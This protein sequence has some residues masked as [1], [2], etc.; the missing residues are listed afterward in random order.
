MKKIRQVR[1]WNAKE[2]EV[3]ADFVVIVDGFTCRIWIEG[4]VQF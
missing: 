4:C 1:T 2:H 3:E